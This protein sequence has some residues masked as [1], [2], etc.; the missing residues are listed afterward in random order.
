MDTESDPGSIAPNALQRGENIRLRGKNIVTRPGLNLKITVSDKAVMMMKELPTESSRMWASIFGCTGSLGEAGYEIAKLDRL[1]NPLYQRYTSS[2]KTVAQFVPLATYGDTLYA[3]DESALCVV[4][5]ITAPFGVPTGS[6]MG[7][8]PL[9]PKWSR[10][11]G[12]VIT[13][14]KEFDGKLWIGLNNAGTGEIWSFNGSQFS[15][16][17][18]GIGSPQAMG[19]VKTQLVVGFDITANYIKTREAGASSTWSTFS[20]VNFSASRYQNSMQEVGSKLYIAGGT[21]SL[22]VYDPGAGSLTL[23]RTIAGAETANDGVT[24]LCLHDGLLHYGWNDNSGSF[25]AKIGRFDPDSTVNDWI[26]SYKTVTASLSSFRRLTAMAS[27]RR[28][29][30]IGGSN[31]SVVATA[32]NDVQGTLE[33]LN[34][35]GSTNNLNVRQLLVTR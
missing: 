2:F 3:G 17:L 26:D 18:S 29:I 5:Q 34:G 28:Q 9:I 15:L 19:V 13:C 27:H 24:A 23:A 14:M 6:I 31:Y 35:G 4:Y 8:N 32:A 30:W 16:E 20:L 7:M 21:T 1:S 25:A 33:T 22:F 10:G 11:G 12:Y